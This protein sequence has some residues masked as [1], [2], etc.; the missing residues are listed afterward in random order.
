[1]SAS[2]LK[3]FCTLRTSLASTQTTWGAQDSTHVTCRRGCCAKLNCKGRARACMCMRVCVRA[4]T[5]V[6]VRVW[7]LCH[8]RAYHNC[9]I[10]IYYFK[11]K[12]S[13]SCAYGRHRH[14][15]SQAACIQTTDACQN[16]CI[17]CV[18]HLQQSLHHTRTDTQA[19]T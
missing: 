19:Q 9:Q 8:M 4:C 7:S 5:Y 13:P 15:Y 10:S 17:P 12:S 2:F 18:L 3:F 16:T 1:M 11:Q 6:R 14:A